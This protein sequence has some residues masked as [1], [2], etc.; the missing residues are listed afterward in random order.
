MCG[1]SFTAPEGETVTISSRVVHK[2]MPAA[3]FKPRRGAPS[4]LFQK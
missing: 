4:E 1:R 3:R 2:E